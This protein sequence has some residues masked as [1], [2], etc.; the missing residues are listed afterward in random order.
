[1][2]EGINSTVAA[3][4][5]AIRET[6]AR[7]DAE[8]KFAHAI[9]VSMLPEPSPDFPDHPQFR[10]CAVMRTAREVGG[11][12]YD[13]QVIDGD[14]VCFLVA[15]VSGKGIPAALFMMTSKMLLHNLAASGLPAAAVFTEGNRQICENNEA[16]MFVTAWMGILE[17]SSGRLECV[18]AGHNPPLLK[19]CQGGYDYLRIRPG[20]VLGGMDNVTYRSHQVVLAP[21]DRL[22]LYTDGVTEAQNPAGQLWG[23]DRLVQALPASVPADAPLSQILAGVKAAIDA[24]AQGASQ[25]DD[26]TMLTLEYRGPTSAAAAADEVT[27]A[28]TVEN[29]LALQEFVGARLAGLDTS[30]KVRNQVQVAAE[31]VFVN[32]ARYA[33]AGGVGAA[34]VSFRP[35]P[36]PPARVV[37]QFRDRGVPF[38]PLARPAPD[39]TLPAEERPVGGLGI[40]LVR[41]SMDAV[42]YQYRDGQ[43]VLT[44][45]RNL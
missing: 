18:N 15:D 43:N 44:I 41:K 13:Y 6:A 20:L 28:A 25:A 26:I 34:T 35:E 38:D 27:L 14:H 31:E 8:L 12:F 36:G 9:Q 30:A 32:I 21:G 45:S 16:G 4:K 5:R 17:L 24:F 7:I 42:D 2:S 22:I 39:V 37:L 3:L 10:L 29:V 23:E 1:L 11:D 33:Y 40:Y 19:R